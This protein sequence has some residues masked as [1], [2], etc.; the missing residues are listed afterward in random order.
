VVFTLPEQISAIALGNKKLVY[1]L[2]F[3][4]ATETLT[5]IARDPEHLGAE[6]GFVAVLHTWTQTLLH[7]P[8]VH[9]VVPG[10][11]LSPDGTRWIASRANF[12][13]SV[14]VLSRL[15]RGKLL[16]LLTKVVVAGKVRFKGST[17]H[18]SEP[19]AWS[20]FCNEMCTKEWVVYSKPPFGSP[21]QVLKYLA[22]YTHRVAISNSRIV[23]MSDTHVSFRYRDRA[24]GD[25]TRT[26]TLDGV[27]FLRRFL[28]H[29]LPKGFVRIR[30]Y[31][32]LANRNRK[33]KLTACRALL[34]ATQEPPS[35][36]QSE[37][38]EVIDGDGALPVRANGLCPTCRLGH[39][40][41]TT[42]LRPHPSWLVCLSP[43]LRDTS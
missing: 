41:R 20:R 25:I 22:R 12:F 3:Q 35:P 21:E 10:G 38:P 24:R 1:G 29:L 5:Q 28:L 31:G 43:S 32:F 7:H 2:L 14:R 11:G 13:L 17:A 34:G 40:R 19:G 26:M 8:H 33:S 15:F 39:L 42:R 9:C 37:Q 27:E 23:S 6:I 18:L 4:A 30:H 36:T 16:A